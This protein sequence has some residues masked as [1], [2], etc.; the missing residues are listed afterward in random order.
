M[1]KSKDV[2]FQ[3]ICFTVNNYKLK[4]VKQLFSLEYKYIVLG[5]EVA[6]S[7]GTPHIQGFINLT[8][9]YRFE[10][11]KR[12]LPPNTHFEKARGTDEENKKYCTKGDSYAE[13][14]RI[15]VQGQR[16][17]LRATC[18]DIIKGNSL[19][20]IAETYPE[21]YVRYYR[22]LK[23]FK[24]QISPVEPRKFKTDVWV[25]VGPPGCGKSLR[26]QCESDGKSTYYKPRGEWWDGYCQQ[27]CVIID[28]FYGWIKYDE[29]LKICDRYPHKVPIKG[30][31]E[32]FASKI[33]YITSNVGVDEWYKFDKYNP[34][35]L[36]RRITKYLVWEIDDNGLYNTKDQE[37]FRINF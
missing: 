36:L 7:T 23:A 22:G 21:T 32:E 25:F 16:T 12:L 29:M 3:R 5:Y 19:K 14:G 20:R 30:G 11:L 35:A 4:D 10:Q 1:S 8:A 15:S 24:D 18:E 37:L 34:T 27:E 28:D 6:P 9:R 33:I 31:F 13:D 17:D 26:A 2:K